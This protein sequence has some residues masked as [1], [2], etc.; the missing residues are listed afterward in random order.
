MKMRFRILL[1]LLFIPAA[2]SAETGHNAWLRYAPLDETTAQR[3][4]ETLPSAIGALNGSAPVQS[5]QQEL[6]AG[7]RGML[8]RTLRALNGT[9]AESAI[10]LATLSDLRRNGPP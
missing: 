2:L 3:Y 1:V 4:R 8:G 6:T 9:P 5:A 10:I 7:I